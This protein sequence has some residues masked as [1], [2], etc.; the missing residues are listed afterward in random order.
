MEFFGSFL[1]R[2]LTF[3][4]DILWFFVV[5][6]VETPACEDQKVKQKAQMT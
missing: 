6:R 3:H 2:C 4:Q 1:G 5:G